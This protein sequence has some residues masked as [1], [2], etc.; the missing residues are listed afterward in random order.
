[1]EAVTSHLL[2]PSSRLQPLT[3][4]ICFE[5]QELTQGNRALFSLPKRLQQLCP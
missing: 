2:P 3:S 1:M 4:Q 5:P